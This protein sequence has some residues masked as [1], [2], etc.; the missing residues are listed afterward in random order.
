MQKPKDE[1]EHVNSTLHTG[2]QLKISTEEFSGE[3]EDNGSTLDTQETE[4]QHCVYITN[5]EDDLQKAVQN[6]TKKK[7]QRIKAC[8]EK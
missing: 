6:C 3:T 7:A 4:Q 5:L 1:E 2:N 8:S